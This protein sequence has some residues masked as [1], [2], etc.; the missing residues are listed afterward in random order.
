MLWDITTALFESV[1]LTIICDVF[2]ASILTY[3]LFSQVG[4]PILD[5]EPNHLLSTVSASGTFIVSER[6]L[7][8]L[9]NL[10][11]FHIF[12]PQ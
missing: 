11:S 8:S 2:S 9:Y 1:L 3:L 12:S 4:K 7:V 5:T 6:H 10:S